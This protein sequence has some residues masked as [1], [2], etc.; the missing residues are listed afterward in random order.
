M[1]AANK[2]V[3]YANNMRIKYLKYCYNF[4]IHMFS[5]EFN[6]FKSNFKN[7]RI[8]HSHKRRDSNYD[9]HSRPQFVDGA[10]AARRPHA[11]DLASDRSDHSD[12]STH[13]LR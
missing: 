9:V 11:P 7:M 10:S 5:I 1:K 8:G 6:R 4:K 2:I 13:A 3:K 12:A